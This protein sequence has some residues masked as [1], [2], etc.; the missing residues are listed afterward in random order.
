MFYFRSLSDEHNVPY[1]SEFLGYFFYWCLCERLKLKRFF[2]ENFSL[3]GSLFVV[4]S[5]IRFSSLTLSVLLSRVCDVSP[6]FVDVREE[7]EPLKHFSVTR[8]C[9]RPIMFVVVNYLIERVRNSVYDSKIPS[10]SPHIF[11]APSHARKKILISLTESSNHRNHVHENNCKK[12]KNGSV[13]SDKRLQSC[14][15]GRKWRYRSAHESFD[16]EQQVGHRSRDLR[17]GR[18]AGCGC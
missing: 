12:C 4:E 2:F 1:F 6:F 3:W 8:L 15:S 18:R 5:S 14:C 10:S 9:R 16:D 7:R 13:E 17:Y 11:H